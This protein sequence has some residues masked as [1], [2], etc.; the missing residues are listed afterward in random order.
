MSHDHPLKGKVKALYNNRLPSKHLKA[1]H[2]R[3]ASDTPLLAGRWRPGNVSW[4][5]AV[6][7]RLLALVCGVY[8]E[9]VTFPLV[10][11]VRCGTWLYRFLIFAPLL[12]F[13][14]Y[15]S[16]QELII[17]WGSTIPHMD[18]VTFKTCMYSILTLRIRQR[19]LYM[20][21]FLVRKTLW[22]DVLKS[23][24]LRMSGTELCDDLVNF[25]LFVGV[26]TM[27][28]WQRWL[29]ET[30]REVNSILQNLAT[31]QPAC[32]IRPPAKRKLKWPA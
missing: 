19:R 18:K 12:T 2:Y 17:L 20:N 27:N 22:H 14:R 30:T 28:L 24:Y 16:M 21:W 32:T 10:S 23:C 31:T 11:W 1:G 13:T 6:W 5:R 25:N 15:I 3:S 26:S 8:C 9:F 29:G 4:L 7:A